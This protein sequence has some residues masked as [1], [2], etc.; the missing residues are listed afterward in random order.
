MK[1][2]LDHGGAIWE[3]GL[4]HGGVIWRGICSVSA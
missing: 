4:D 1:R 2:G 3:R